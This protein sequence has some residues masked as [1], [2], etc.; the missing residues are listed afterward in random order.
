MVLVIENLDNLLH[1]EKGEDQE[2]SYPRG[3]E[4]CAKMN[5]KYKK[6]DFFNFHKGNWAN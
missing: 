1:L 2:S 5:G 3:E 6:N 4:Y